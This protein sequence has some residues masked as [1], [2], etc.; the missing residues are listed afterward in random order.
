[1]LDGLLMMT[2]GL[3]LLNVRRGILAT[4]QTF[5]EAAEWENWEVGQLF[6]NNYVLDVANINDMHLTAFKLCYASI[7]YETCNS[8]CLLGQKR[9]VKTF[10]LD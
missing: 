5:K 3:L 9:E 1:M 8:Q 6:N 4:A 10:C 2:D 7:R